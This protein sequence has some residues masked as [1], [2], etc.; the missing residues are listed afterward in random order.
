MVMKAIQIALI[1]MV[2]FSIIAWARSDF[3]FGHIAKVLPFCSGNE[4][5]LWYDLIGGTSLV[6]LCLW[7]LGRVGRLGDGDKTPP[8]QDDADEGSYE[9]DNPDY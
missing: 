2:T 8:Q 9:D 1:L 6:L 5:S 3:D 4:P 7:G